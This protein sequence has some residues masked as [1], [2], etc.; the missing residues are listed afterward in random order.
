MLRTVNLRRV[1]TA[2]DADA[3]VHDGEALAAEQQN[4]LEDLVAQQL[5]LDQLDG[6]AVD[7][8]QTAALL[9]IRDGDRRLLATKGLDRLRRRARASVEGEREERGP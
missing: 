3:Q 5:R 1:A 4:R 9:A 2:L 6:A 8:D 7:L